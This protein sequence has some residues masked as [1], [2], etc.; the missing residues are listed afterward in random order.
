[1]PV[2]RLCNR[3]N[4]RV[5]LRRFAFGLPDGNRFGARPHRRNPES[6]SWWQSSFNR[7]GGGRGQLSEYHSV[8][9]R[10]LPSQGGVCVGCHS[11]S[12]SCGP[13]RDCVPSKA[14]CPTVSVHLQA[15][16]GNPDVLGHVLR[17]V[18][19]DL[20]WTGGYHGKHSQQLD[21][22]LQATVSGLGRLERKGLLQLGV[23]DIGLP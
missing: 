10:G 3:P 20:R 23:F 22:A 13:R 12:A 11:G 1:M 2:Q 14:L 9:R 16:E 6:Y 15:I 18:C 4:R 21:M 19:R 7:Y 8:W 17:G 5:R